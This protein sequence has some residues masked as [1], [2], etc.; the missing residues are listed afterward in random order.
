M[1]STSEGN[2]CVWRNYSSTWVVFYLIGRQCAL[3]EW[4]LEVSRPGFKYQCVSL[5]ALCHR[6]PGFLSFTHL[7]W[8]IGESFLTHRVGKRLNKITYYSNLWT[9]EHCLAH[10]CCSASVCSSL[11]PLIPN[12]IGGSGLSP[13]WMPASEC[14][15]LWP[16]VRS[17]YS[18]Q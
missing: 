4:T 13:S 1:I 9:Y 10:N 18:L 16:Y 2:R 5:T 3:V 6:P 8:T 11:P 12:W 7:I 15:K 14:Q 17:H